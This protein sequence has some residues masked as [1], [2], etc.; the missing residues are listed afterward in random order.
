MTWCT[1]YRRPGRRDTHGGSLGHR[2]K[3]GDD[4]FRARPVRLS[5]FE[6]PC[7]AASR[8]ARVPVP[9]P[10]ATIAAR[11]GAKMKP[12]PTDHARP[13]V[14]FMVATGAIMVFTTTDAIVKAMPAG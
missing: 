13:A 5:Y 7:N 14:P 4:D 10:R 12:Y 6:T 2:V 11:A 9:P 1:T 8:A 3:P